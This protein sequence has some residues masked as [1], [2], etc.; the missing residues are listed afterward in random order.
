MFWSYGDIFFICGFM[1]PPPPS[2]RSYSTFYNKFISRSALPVLYALL[3]M[4]F[5]N[6]VHVHITLM[7]Y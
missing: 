7:M 1:P 2:Y 4:Y 6:I 3:I 5:I